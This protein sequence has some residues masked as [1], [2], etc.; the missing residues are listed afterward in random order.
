[1]D[2]FLRDKA[3]RLV[4]V[5]IRKTISKVDKTYDISKLRAKYKKTTLKLFAINVTDLD[6][7]AVVDVTGDKMELIGEGPVSDYADIDSINLVV[8]LESPVLF[9]IVEM[10]T[11]PLKA[12]MLGKIKILKADT[13]TMAADLKIVNK[14]FYMIAASIHT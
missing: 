6:Y 14:V 10:R 2:S 11:D 1:M 4:M 8:N 13:N 7:S 3:R 5:I 12:Y 9:D